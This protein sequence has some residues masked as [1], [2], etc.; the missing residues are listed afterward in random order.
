MRPLQIV[1]SRLISQL[2]CGLKPPASTR[3]QICLKMAR[4]SSR[5]GDS[6]GLCPQ[7]VPG[8][9]VLPLP[10]GGHGEQGAQR[11]APRHSRM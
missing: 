5:L 3:N 8:V 6:P 4:P 7:P 10:A 1:P 9:G 11:W 2:Y